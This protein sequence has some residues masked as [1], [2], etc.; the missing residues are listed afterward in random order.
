MAIR[1]T[2]SAQS[3][4]RRPPVPWKAG[5][6]ATIQRLATTFIH[7]DDDCWISHVEE[8]S[9]GVARDAEGRAI[10]RKRLPMER[11][12]SVQGGSD[13]RPLGRGSRVIADRR[14]LAGPP[15]AAG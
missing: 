9:V 15:L 5:A 14:P 11:V 2:L 12:L 6:A 1:G 4:N 7:L 13:R 3:A 8:S 10:S